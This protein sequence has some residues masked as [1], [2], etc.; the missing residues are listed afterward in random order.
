MACVRS[1]PSASL[2]TIIVLSSMLRTASFGTSYVDTSRSRSS[3][4]RVVNAPGVG[5]NRLYSASS[6]LP[7]NAAPRWREW[8]GFLCVCSG[9]LGWL[10]PASHRVGCAR[11]C[12]RAT[13]RGLL[14]GLVVTAHQCQERRSE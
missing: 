5:D 10:P 7:A 1:T 13:Y 2:M 6:G 9:L 11:S 4:T 14:G 12:G 3:F 8:P